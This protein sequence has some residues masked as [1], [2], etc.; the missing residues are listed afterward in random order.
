MATSMTTRLGKIAVAAAAAVGLY[1]PAIDVPT[2]LMACLH[3]ANIASAAPSPTCSSDL[4]ECLHASVKTGLYGVRY[5]APEDVARCVEA[6][7]ACR[8]GGAGGGGNPNPPPS[9]PA[10]GGTGKGL[11]SHL[12][13]KTIGNGESRYDCRVNGS[14]VSCAGTLVAKFGTTDTYE[15]QFTGTLSGLTATGTFNGHQTGH[16]PADPSCRYE[17]DLS[18]PATF[19]FNLDGTVLIRQGPPQIHGTY[20]CGG[21]TSFTGNAW[22]STGTWSAMT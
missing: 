6:F 10:G 4:R 7:N 17:Q 22:E 13:I 15:E 21:P 16:S 8:H 12:G 2:S 3:P 5:V 11:P 18:G 14:S 1:V 9:T 20:S 19:I